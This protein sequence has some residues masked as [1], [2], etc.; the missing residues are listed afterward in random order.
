MPASQER[1]EALASRLPIGRDR[2]AVVGRIEA[3][4]HLLEHLSFPGST[5]RSAS[6]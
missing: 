3:M 2:A 5:A 1:F 4:E 6:T